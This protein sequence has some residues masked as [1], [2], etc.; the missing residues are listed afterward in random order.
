MDGMFWCVEYIA[1]FVDVLMGTYFCGTFI[2]RDEMRN[3]K[4]KIIGASF[5]GA[6]IIILLNSIDLFSYITAYIGIIA[7]IIIQWVCYRKKYLLSVGLVFAYEVFLVTVDFI[8]V[9][10]ASVIMDIKI[11]YILEEQS[12]IRLACILLSK[13]VLIIVIVSLNR[14]FSYK[15]IIQPI[16]IVVMCVCSIF[17]F[18]S[19]MILVHLELT[20]SN[21]ETSGFT[22]IFLVASFFIEILFF[23]LVLKIAEGYEQKQMNLLVEMNNKMLQKSLKETE[24]TFELWRHS[25]HDYKNHVIALKQMA[26]EDKFEE[27]KSYLTQEAENIDKKIFLLKTGNS[28][29][30]TIINVKNSLAEKHG[31]AF[32]AHA[33]LPTQLRISDIDVTNVLGNILDNAIEA[34]EKEENP[35]IDIMIKQEKN[36]LIINVRNKCT[37]EVEEELGKTSKADVEFHGIGL[38][39][40]NRVVKKYD[41]EM[42]IE[43]RN[44][45]YIVT[46][47]IPN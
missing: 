33:K 28:A 24:Q 10:L 14:V 18:L 29:V 41:G 26:D 23:F 30:D 43:Q 13:S 2:L 9:Y 44:Q 32:M 4:I 21:E 37:K 20:L 34:S 27:I 17:L 5:I 11:D 22:M 7:F 12:F 38:K 15:K 6:T 31:I 46:I 42:N 35:Y 1:S 25:V 3:V 36:F 40:V 8:A 47:M 39:S 16:Y 19:N 45:E